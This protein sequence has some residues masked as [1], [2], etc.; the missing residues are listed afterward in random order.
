[1]IYH[2]EA[3]P[4]LSV[5]DDPAAY[6]QHLVEKNLARIELPLNRIIK[7]YLLNGGY[8]EYFTAD[9]TPYWQK[10]LAEDIISKGLYRDIVSFYRVNSPVILERMLYLIAANSG[11]EY[12]YA[13]LGEQLHIDTTTATTYVHYLSQAFLVTVLEN[14][15]PN[16]N[17]INRKNKK[18]YVCDNGIRNAILRTPFLK[19]EEEGRLVEGACVRMARAYG[20][21]N[22]FSLYYWRDKQRETDIVIDKKTGLLPIEVKYRNQ[23]KEDDIRGLRV[24]MEKYRIDTGLVITKNTLRR[25][26]GICYIPLKYIR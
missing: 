25:E 7:D 6:Y 22:F 26:E 9:G 2:A 15:S 17:R 3:M 5:F 1:M 19:P 18:I 8:P 23:I 12:A 24:F 4:P 21:G 20:E 10:I 16:A 13:G 14:Y 11:G